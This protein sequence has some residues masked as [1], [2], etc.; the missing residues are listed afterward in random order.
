VLEYFG[1]DESVAGRAVGDKLDELK[2]RHAL[3][4]IHERGNVALEARCAG[5]KKAFGGQTDLLY[6]DG[7]DM[8]AVQAAVTARLRQDPSIDEV[9]T[10]GAQ[11]ALAA[12]ASVRQSGSM[13]HVATFDLN[14]DL[15]KAVQSGDVQFAVDQQPYL[16]GY[17]AVDALWLYRTNGNV[18]GGGAAPVLTGPA[19]VTKANV[20][21]VARFAANGTR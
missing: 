12:V 7:T 19:F 14:Q 10:L 8:D 9:V 4:V 1:Q 11:Y 17:L 20:S 16:Q 21:S 6:V 3:C 5:V 2:A 13:A 15:V 18:S